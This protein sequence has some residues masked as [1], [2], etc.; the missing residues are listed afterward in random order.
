MQQLPYLIFLFIVCLAGAVKD[1]GPTVLVLLRFRNAGQTFTR[2][3]KK[4]VTHMGRGRVTQCL[5]PWLRV[6]H[7]GSGPSCVL[8]DSR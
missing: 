1:Q 7:L 6:G 3:D 5:E 8:C 2:G 4:W